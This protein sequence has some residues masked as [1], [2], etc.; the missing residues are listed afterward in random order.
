MI[1][2]G[3]FRDGHQ[4]EYDAGLKRLDTCRRAVGERDLLGARKAQ[5]AASAV[6]G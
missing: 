2:A 4:S 5:E 3:H 6:A 1:A